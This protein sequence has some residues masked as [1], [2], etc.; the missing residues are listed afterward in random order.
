MMIWEEKLIMADKKKAKKKDEIEEVNSV[1]KENNSK[2]K[3]VLKNGEKN[4]SESIKDKNKDKI[5]I[6]KCI[7]EIED[8]KNQN[9]TLKDD[10]VR[11]VAEFDNFRKRTTKEKLDITLEEK[12]KTVATL[13]PAIDT[14]EKALEYECSDDEFKKGIDMISSQLRTTLEKLGVEEIEALNNPFNPDYH[15]AISQIQDETMG[16]NT[17]SSVCQKGYKIGERVVR[18]AMVIVANP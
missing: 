15:N 18:H 12:I 10:F 1:E 3:D 11:K 17:V 14:F 13:L 9:A 7:K 4:L 6:E 2:D 5:E 16:E 8:L